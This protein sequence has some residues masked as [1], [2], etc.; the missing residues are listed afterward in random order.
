MDIHDAR[1]TIAELLR[2]SV[3]WAGDRLVDRVL[4]PGEPSVS[5]AARI[6]MAHIDPEGV[7]ASE[8]A[9]QLRVS[10]QH[11]HARV[12]ELLA[13]GLVTVHPAPGSGRERIIRAT[14]AGE[15]RRQRALTQLWSLDE[16]IAE[17][18]GREDLEHLRSTLLRLLDR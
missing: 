4:Q 11:V 1:S 7:T 10:R 2:E 8:V 6:V 18:I 13:V 12:Q 3:R 5:P 17:R 14:E 15:S 16:E 9:R